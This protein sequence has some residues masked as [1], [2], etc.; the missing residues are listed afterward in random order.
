M[1]HPISYYA[2]AP[3]GTQD[4]TILAEFVSHHGVYLEKLSSEDKLALRAVLC[5]YLYYGQYVI[6]DYLIE[7]AITDIM[8]NLDARICSVFAALEGISYNNAEGL[9]KFITD[10]VFCQTRRGY[11]IS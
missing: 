4:A 9:L 1:I 10:Q 2:A 7:D 8:P 11:K 6:Q 5:M 3:D